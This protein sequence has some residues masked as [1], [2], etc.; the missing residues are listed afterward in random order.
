MA[1]SVPQIAFTDQGVIVPQEADILAGTQADVNG[2]FGGVLGPG[3]TTP[4]GQVASSEAAIIADK[5]GQI[6]FVSNQFDPQYASGRW[7]DGIARIYFLTR[8]PAQATAVTCILGGIASTPIPAGTLAQDQSGNSYVLLTSVTIG[9]GGTV[10]SQW[11]NQATGAIPC[12]VGTLTRVFQQIN[13][14]DTITNPS[15]GILGN[16]VESRADFEFRRQ[17][18]V[19]INGRGTNQAIYAVV[20][21]IDNVLD[22]FVIDNPSGLTQSSNPLPGGTPNPSNYPLAPHSIYIAVVGGIDA[23]IAAAIWGK[24]DDGCDY[25]PFPVGQS[26]VPGA[27]TVSTQ[28]VADTTYSFPQPQYQVSFIRPVGLPIFFS[29][30][31]VNTPNLPVG[32]TALV[33]AAIIAQFQGQNGN[34]RAR[35]GGSVIAAQYYAVVSNIGSFVTLLGVQVGFSASPSGEQAQVGIDQ[36]PSIAAGN[37]TV[38]YV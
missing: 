15:D 20:F 11:Q 29:V 4:Q 2:A 28:T 16:V 18:S 33:Q 35:I 26:P 9:A 19:A 1:T 10:T 22:C 8:K 23:Q 30:Q 7:Q 21:E 17:N 25:A 24:K 3:L 37:I 34:Q 36:T 38:T 31:I 27:G 14:W 6:L 5:D 13:G 12:P 32:L